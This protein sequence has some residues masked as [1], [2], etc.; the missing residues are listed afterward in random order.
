M[1]YWRAF[2]ARYF[3][4]EIGINISIFAVA[5]DIMQIKNKGAGTC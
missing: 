2:V 4:L 1:D 5:M 3:Y